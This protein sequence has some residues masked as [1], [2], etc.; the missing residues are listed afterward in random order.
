MAGSASPARSRLVS[1]I[2]S[3]PTISS[4]CSNSMRVLYQGSDAFSLVV[5]DLIEGRGKRAPLTQDYIA[6]KKTID[7]ALYARFKKK[8]EMH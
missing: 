5:T 8:L 4:N 3:S 2:G 6:R 7:Y 1:K